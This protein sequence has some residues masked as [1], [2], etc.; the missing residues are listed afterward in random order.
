M[1]AIAGVL[2]GCGDVHL[3]SQHGGGRTRDR[4]GGKFESSLVYV[5]GHPEIYRETYLKKK[6][7]NR[8]FSKTLV[9]YP[10]KGLVKKQSFVL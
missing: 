8:E 1:A 3:S 10:F 4:A 7:G 2:T 6:I 9:Q 5:S